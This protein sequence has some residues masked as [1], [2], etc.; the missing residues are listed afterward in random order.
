MVF[1]ELW[2]VTKDVYVGPAIANSLFIGYHAVIIEK[3]IEYWGD[4]VAVCRMSNG[5][6][7]GDGGYVYVLLTVFYMTLSMPP[8]DEKKA[9]AKGTTKPMHLLANFVILDM[10][11]REGD[12]ME[13][14]EE[15]RLRKMNEQLSSSFSADIDAPSPYVASVRILASKKIISVYW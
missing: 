10:R 2:S 7:V 12:D 9:V 4:I 13:I 3:V 5:D 15:E 6:A 8:R 11:R 1:L 14:K